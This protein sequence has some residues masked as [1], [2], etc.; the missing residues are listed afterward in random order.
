MHFKGALQ[1]RQ[2]SLAGKHLEGDI[3]AK[4]ARLDSSELAA[5]ILPVFYPK[6]G[7]FFLEGQP[8]TG[9]FLLRAGRV[10]ESMASNTGKTAIVRV[11]GPGVILGLSAVLTGTPHECTV[12]T[13]EATHADFVRKAPFL[14]LLKTSGQLGQIVAN[15]LSGNC[16]EAYTAIRCLGISGSVTERLARLLLQWAEKCP[17]ENQ[18]RDRAGV[19]I[20]VTLTHEEISQFVGS[21]RETTSRILG[22]FREKEWLSI[23]GSIWTLANESALRRLAA[24]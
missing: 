13:L 12:E 22:R 14:H 11:S 5:G 18:N 20:R 2:N 21:T 19:R 9:V 24:V 6:G 10:K 17:L 3:S 16:K 23:N 7:M 4:L 1:L 15:Q 8:A